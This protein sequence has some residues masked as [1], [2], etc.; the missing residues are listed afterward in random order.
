[1]NQLEKRFTDLFQ[2]EE[3]IRMIFSGKRKK[4]LPYSKVILRPVKLSGALLYQEEFTFDKKVT[5]RNLSPSEALD[6][7]L[8]LFTEDFKQGN[9]FTTAEDIQILAS[10]PEN[11][12]FTTRPATKGMPSLDHNKTKKYMIADGSPCDFLIRLGVMDTSGK[13]VQR[14]YSKFRQINRYLEIVEDVFPA[15]P[16]GRPLRIIDFGCGKAYLTFALYY[17]LRILRGRD[18]EVVGLDL[19][20]DVIQFCNKIASDLNYDGLTF[21]LGDIADY[22]NDHADMVVTLH[23]CDT[24]TDYALINAVSWNAPVILSVPAASTNCF[25]MKTPS[26]NPC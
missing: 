22:K 5:H 26:I 21:L 8:R 23:A 9:V 12:R 14:H 20:K 4:S 17:Y 11:P 24:A 18:V 25:Q 2:N 19:K 10:K 3:I 16:Q 13:V 6:E 15:L 1:M 7:T